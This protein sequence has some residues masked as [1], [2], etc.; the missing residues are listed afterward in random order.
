MTN[1]EKIATE[2]RILDRKRQA[3]RIV[4]H[5]S[6]FAAVA[7]LSPLP[8]TDVAGIGGVQLTMLIKISKIYNIEANIDYFGNMIKGSLGG[9]VTGKILEWASSMVKTI[10]GIGTILGIAIQ[11]P[12]AFV[13]TYA[14]GRAFIF[15][16]EEGKSP[17]EI[18]EQEFSKK[19]NEFK[20]E[21][22]EEFKKSKNE[23]LKKKDDKKY[24]KEERREIEELLKPFSEVVVKDFI[25]SFIQNLKESREIAIQNLKLEED[26][27]E[28]IKE[29]KNKKG[30]KD[31]DE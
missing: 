28:V 12:V 2:N 6:I 4:K 16:L 29:I 21:A 19:M 13:V 3:L 27:N 7:A 8:I 22:K 14:I 17:T 11:P 5:H 9:F 23:I 30:E 20:V 10:P 18:S 31:N 1:K 25:Q 24:I 26:I 15:F